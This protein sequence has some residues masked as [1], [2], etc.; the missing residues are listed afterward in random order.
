MLST[1]WYFAILK[2]DKSEVSSNKQLPWNYLDS[3]G[4]SQIFVTFDFNK[5]AHPWLESFNNKSSTQ[6]DVN[7]CVWWWKFL[8]IIINSSVLNYVHSFKISD[9]FQKSIQDFWFF[10]RSRLKAPNY[11]IYV[12]ITTFNDTY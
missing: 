7:I 3:I 6:S 8:V 4:E 1:L 10:F 5:V 9:F 11:C 12:T 2:D